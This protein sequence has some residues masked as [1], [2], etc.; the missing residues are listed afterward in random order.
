MSFIHD[1]FVLSPCEFRVRGEVAKMGFLTRIFKDKAKAAAP[2]T[3]ADPGPSPRSEVS[4]KP[5]D[6]GIEDFPVSD[7]PKAVAENRAEVVSA[8]LRKGLDVETKNWQGLTMLQVAVESGSDR[9]LD[10]LIKAGANVNVARGD[11][12]LEAASRPR[13]QIVRALIEAGAYVNARTSGGYTPLIIAA[14]RGYTESVR[15]LLAAGANVEAR[16]DGNGKLKS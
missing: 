8:L 2:A 10:V 15:L 7:W 5:A 11:P 16:G 13:P 1:S 4:S 6:A 12:L 9:V 14:G 3:S